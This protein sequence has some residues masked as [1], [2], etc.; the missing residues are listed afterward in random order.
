MND[1]VP[2]DIVLSTKKSIYIIVFLCLCII[3]FSTALLIR[4]N[5]NNL[6]II[7]SSLNLSIPLVLLTFCY[8]I[9]DNQDYYNSTRISATLNDL[10]HQHANLQI[11]NRKLHTD[12]TQVINNSKIK[13]KDTLA[14]TIKNIQINNKNELQQM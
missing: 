9:W 6:D 1:F 14:N 5:E 2:N 8:I 10:S 4:N 11:N 3:S 12:I 13:D 7:L